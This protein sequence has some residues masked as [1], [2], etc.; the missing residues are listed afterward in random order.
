ANMH[1][2]GGYFAVYGGT[3]PDTYAECL[4]TVRVEL[5]KIREGGVSDA[6][7]ARAKAQ[8][9]SGL[10]MKQESMSARMSRIGASEIYYGRVVPLAEALAKMNAI[11][12]DD[13]LSVARAVLPEDPMQLTVTAVGPFKKRR[14]AGSKKVSPVA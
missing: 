1:R 10:V 13:V 6:E 4:D 7:L 11:T 14:A 8:A 9:R 3:S 12:P 2:E 5:A